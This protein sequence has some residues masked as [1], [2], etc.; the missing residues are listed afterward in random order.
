MV[1]RTWWRDR[2]MLRTT[3]RH[4]SDEFAT[5]NV[6]GVGFHVHAHGRR[7][8]ELLVWPEG[9]LDNFVVPVSGSQTIGDACEDL[10]EIVARYAVGQ[11][12]PFG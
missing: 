7:S 5:L 1:A 8:L 4:L 11:R 9:G 12:P 10:R 2:Q 3:A 6:E